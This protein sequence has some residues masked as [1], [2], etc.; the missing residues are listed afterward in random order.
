MAQLTPDS[1][2]TRECLGSFRAPE[3][4]VSHRR[5]RRRH[6]L[7]VGH[8]HDSHCEV[9]CA[10]RDRREGVCGLV[11]GQWGG[12]AHGGLPGAER[13][14]HTGP[15]PLWPHLPLRPP[16]PGAVPALPTSAAGSSP[17][18]LLGAPC[19]Q[20]R[21]W[22]CTLAVGCLLASMMSVLSR[23]PASYLGAAGSSGRLCV[24]AWP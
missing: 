1:W 19:E 13:A 12:A 18:F 14:C 2:L 3:A 6:S 9:P 10:G 17:L 4:A 22:R 21:R 23:A 8:K 5:V 15:H 7:A 24:L 11:Q 20:G 16:W